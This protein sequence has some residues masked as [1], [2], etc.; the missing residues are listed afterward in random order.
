[1]VFDYPAQEANE[2]SIKVGEIVEVLQMKDCGRFVVEE[3][4]WKVCCRGRM[5]RAAM[6]VTYSLCIDIVLSG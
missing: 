5:H 2:L 1:M 4:W 3:G 6:Y